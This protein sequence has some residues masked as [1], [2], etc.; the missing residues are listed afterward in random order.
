MIAHSPATACGL[1]SAR[2]VENR[3]TRGAEDEDKD[4]QSARAP[5]L[6]NGYPSRNSFGGRSGEGGRKMAGCEAPVRMLHMA[7]SRQERKNLICSLFLP[8]CT[9]LDFMQIPTGGS[10]PSGAL[11]SRNKVELRNSNQP[12]FRRDVSCC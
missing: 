4:S 11:W 2:G 10:P 1:K 9:G 6:A 3:N 12:D 8:P 7:E 5:A